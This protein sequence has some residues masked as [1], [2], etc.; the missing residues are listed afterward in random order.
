MQCGRCAMEMRNY[1]SQLLVNEWFGLAACRLGCFPFTPNKNQGFKSQITNPKYHK[2]SKQARI[3]GEAGQIWTRALVEHP[4][5]LR[6][7]RN[8]QG[9]LSSSSEG[10]FRNASL[11]ASSALTFASALGSCGALATALLRKL[12]PKMPSSISPIKL[13]AW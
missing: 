11:S 6:L 8:V 4:E 3:H 7:A 12:R 13:G 5:N 1:Q 9:A 10:V 2:R